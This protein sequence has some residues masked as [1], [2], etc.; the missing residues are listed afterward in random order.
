MN[1]PFFT[2]ADAVATLRWSPKDASVVMAA[3]WRTAAEVLP[4]YDLAHMLNN[5]DPFGM[6]YCLDA[7]GISPQVELQLSYY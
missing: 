7:R 5:P 6:A 3:M 2:W 1:H 4:D